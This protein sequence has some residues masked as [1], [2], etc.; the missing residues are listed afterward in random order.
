MET[1]NKWNN[2]NKTWLLDL[3]FGYNEGSFNQVPKI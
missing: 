1:T 3:F 2:K